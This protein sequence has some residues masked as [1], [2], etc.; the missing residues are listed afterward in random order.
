MGF[1]IGQG[2]KESIDTNDDEARSD[3]MYLTPEISI[4]YGRDAIYY[5]L[6]QDNQVKR[7]PFDEA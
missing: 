4:T 6:K 1:A 7:S 3:E 2:V 5:Y